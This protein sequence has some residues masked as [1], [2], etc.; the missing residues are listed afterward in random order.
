[1]LVSEGVAPGQTGN[2]GGSVDR[3][4][5]TPADQV[6]VR[7]G[8]H[9]GP[10]AEDDAH[11]DVSFEV[12]HPPISLVLASPEKR[13]ELKLSRMHLGFKSTVG[14]GAPRLPLTAAAARD[15]HELCNVRLATSFAVSSSIRDA[16]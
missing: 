15:S 14:T 2:F 12:G 8:W 4:V 6:Q 11:R 16:I 5:G 7:W 9:D 1:M 3:H 13:F 10:W